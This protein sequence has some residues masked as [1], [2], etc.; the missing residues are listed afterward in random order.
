MLFRTHR[1]AFL[2]AALIACTPSAQDNAPPDTVSATDDTDSPLPDHPCALAWTGP[3]AMPEDEVAWD[4]AFDGE[5]LWVATASGTYSDPVFRVQR[6]GC[7]GAPIGQPVETPIESGTRGQIALAA[8]GSRALVLWDSSDN[9]SGD[10]MHR[11][12]AQIVDDRGAPVGERLDVSELVDQPYIF[13]WAP[14]SDG[15]VLGV[16]REGDEPGAEVLRIGFDGS[17]TSLW[18]VGRDA[19]ALPQA[20]MVATDQDD[21][22]I[23]WTD[24]GGGTEPPTY[25]YQAVGE[26]P[27]TVDQVDIDGA[28]FHLGVTQGQPWYGMMQFRGSSTWTGVVRVDGTGETQLVEDTDWTD[29]ALGPSGGAIGTHG[30]IVAESSAVVRVDASMRILDTRPMPAGKVA[31]NTTRLDDRSYVIAAVEDDV[32]TVEMLTFDE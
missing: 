2:A 29:F 19:E 8:Q 23:A 6:F 30:Y 31:W 10:W 1:Q 24:D 15:I 5:A 22:H 26:D 16:G 25:V 7:D 9:S 27:V 20:V 28:V 4:V 11:T 17:V 13:D 3:I 21:V 32:G 12:F 18:S 14:L